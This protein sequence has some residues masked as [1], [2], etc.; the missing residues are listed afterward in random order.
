MRGHKTFTEKL[1]NKYNIN[2]VIYS[3]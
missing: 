3:L 1:V 2:A